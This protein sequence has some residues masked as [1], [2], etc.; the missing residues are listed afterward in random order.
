MRTK[1][2]K[3]L[4]TA[5]FFFTLYC[6]TAH[7]DFLVRNK[8]D[9]PIY[10]QTVN[11]VS[12]EI[13]KHVINSDYKIIIPSGDNNRYEY[14]ADSRVPVL[15][16]RIGDK[17][18]RNLSAEKQH[19]SFSC[20]VAVANNGGRITVDY[21]N[22]NATNRNTSEN[23]SCKARD[24]RY[25]LEQ[26]R[27]VRFLIT[28]DPQ[29]WI[30]GNKP[31]TR[32]STDDIKTP[33][34]VSQETINTMIKRFKQ[35]YQYSGFIVAGDLTQNTRTQE[36]KYYKKLWGDEKILRW[37]FDG[38]GNHDVE[39]SNRK[40]IRKTV[41]DEIRNRLRDPITFR[42]KNPERPHYSWDWH[43]VHFVQLNVFP[44]RNANDWSMASLDFLESDLE[45][46]VGESGRPV[47][48]IQHY[49]PD[50]MKSTEQEFWRVING[51]NVIA[52][53]W[54]HSHG[55]G[56]SPSM[57]GHRFHWPWERPSGIT[58]G[59][60]KI[61]GFLSG[62]ARGGQKAG[63]WE[64]DIKKAVSNGVFLDVNINSSFLIVYKIN[65]ATNK[66]D[67]LYCNSDNPVYY[68]LNLYPPVHIP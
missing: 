60:D 46:Q 66:P 2:S 22:P 14:E 42:D 29:V 50:A 49:Y 26:G 41:R 19:A 35:N 16:V 40:D 25:D 8:L 21:I 31:R 59:P 33:Y 43:D 18:H 52:V 54:G 44:G 5:K 12:V 45:L 64:I 30:D 6:T 3:L 68:D 4:I 17:K 1:K 47:V 13:I 56:Y 28:A 53:F 9:V 48:I 24:A 27:N 51:Y 23:I 11:G 10:M 20:L 37:V 36:W 65:G 39:T 67:A 58:V 62:A 15:S 32:N 7:A 61:P 55:W 34:D 38:L 63:L 57:P